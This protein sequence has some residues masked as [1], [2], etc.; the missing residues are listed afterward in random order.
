MDFK[1]GEPSGS[2]FLF[3]GVSLR[4]RLSAVSFFLASFRL[5]SMKTAKKDAA[6]I[7]NAERTAKF[8]F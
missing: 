1:K 7:L 4:V 5:R 8:R 3:L 2:P 6:S